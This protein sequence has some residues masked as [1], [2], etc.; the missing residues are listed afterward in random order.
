MNTEEEKQKDEEVGEG[1]INL[2]EGNLGKEGGEAW[3][4]T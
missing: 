4:K 1:R 2:V 3:A